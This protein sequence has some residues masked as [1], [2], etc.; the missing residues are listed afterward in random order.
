MNIAP[1]HVLLY[2]ESLG[3]SVIIDLASKKDVG[4]VIVEGAFSSGKDIGRKHYPFIPR[5]FLPDIFDSIKK[6]KTVTAPKLFI[7]AAD[8]EVVPFE[9]G[10]KLYEESPGPKEFIKLPGYHNDAFLTSEGEYAE[11][12]INFIDKVRSGLKA[13]N[14]LD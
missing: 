4:A 12:I 9:L 10:R 13:S 3:S 14:A 6:I 2:G 1:G 11:A 8:D 5:V 7:H